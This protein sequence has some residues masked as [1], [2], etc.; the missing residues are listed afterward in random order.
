MQALREQLLCCQQERYGLE[1]GDLA[2]VIWRA[3]QSTPFAF[4]D[5]MWARSTA[6]GSRNAARFEIQR[7]AGATSTYTQPPDTGGTAE[8]WHH[9]GSREAARRSPGGLSDGD[10]GERGDHRQKTGGK[11]EDIYNE[12]VAN[13]VGNAHVSRRHRRRQPRAGARIL[14]AYAG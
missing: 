9:A 3:H 12:L 11:A 10:A 14:A 7:P 13:L 6:P 8:L 4:N 2:V 5:A 1:N